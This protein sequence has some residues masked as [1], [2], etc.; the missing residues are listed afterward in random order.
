MRIEPVRGN[1][2]TVRGPGSRGLAGPEAELIPK[3]RAA[4]IS[5]MAD[6]TELRR[7]VSE[8]RKRLAHVERMSDRAMYEHKREM[9]NDI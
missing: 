8:T 2:A 7:E 6:F 4:L 5:L 1:S 9:K 3:V